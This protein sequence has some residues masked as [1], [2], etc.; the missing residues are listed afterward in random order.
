MK[1]NYAK[2]LASCLTAALA[3]AAT[4][5]QAVE[6]YGIDFTGSGFLTLGAGKI[7]GGGAKS[8]FND[9]TSPTFVADFGQAGMYEK[10]QGLNFAPDSKLGLQGTAKFNKQFSVTGQVVARGAASGK[11]NLEWLYATYNIDDN[12][13]LQIGRKRLPLFYYSES[14]DVGLALPWVRLPPQAYGWD[15][16]NYN[17]INLMHRTQLGAWSVASEVFYGNEKRTDNPYQKIYTGKNTKTDEKW[18]NITGADVSFSRDWF[19]AR[20]MYMQA[21]WQYWDPTTAGS[22]FPKTRQKFFSAAFN[23]DYENWLVRSEFSYINRRQADEND[24]AQLLA[25]GYRIGK[26]L[27][28]ATIARYEGNYIDGGPIGYAGT[29]SEKHTTYSATL[30]YDLTPSSAL[31]VQYDYWKDRSGVTF[32]GGQTFGNPRLLSFSYDMVF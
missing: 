11:T 8:S 15:I 9:Y 3:I 18:T 17:G 23:A 6:A 20:F 31:K 4:P 12:W 29:D 26:W 30:R 14:Q 7:I 5:T 2:T 32:A 1:M 13:S 16:V 28:L 21:D 27:P 22:F 25:V 24:F 10:G 19:E